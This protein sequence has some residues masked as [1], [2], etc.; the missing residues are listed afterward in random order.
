M[1]GRAREAAGIVSYLRYLILYHTNR[2]LLSSAERGNVA[3]TV[4]PLQKTVPIAWTIHS[5]RA[6]Y[7]F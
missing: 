2:C 7:N 3:E 4:Q 5:G 6:E 1:N